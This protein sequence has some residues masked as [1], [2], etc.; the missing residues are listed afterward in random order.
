MFLNIYKYIF[1]T[2]GLAFLAQLVSFAFFSRTLTSDQYHLAVFKIESSVEKPASRVIYR[3]VFGE[4]L[5]QK[6]QQM[7]SDVN[8]AVDL[9]VSKSRGVLLTS[10]KGQFSEESLIG[11]QGTALAASYIV[12]IE[13]QYKNSE[14]FYNDFNFAQKL[15]VISG[16]KVTEFLSEKDKSDM[17]AEV[18]D[19]TSQHLQKQLDIYKQKLGLREVDMSFCEA[20]ARRTE[21]HIPPGD[22]TYSGGLSPEERYPAETE[23]LPSA[24]TFMVPLKRFVVQNRKPDPNLDIHL[25]VYWPSVVYDEPQTREVCL[26]KS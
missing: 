4:R 15:G 18:E 2:I 9:F 5:V 11:S 13:I 12:T 16:E 21:V 10:K 8:K 7:L 19:R 26:A 1:I 3:Y 22:P 20:V 23:K 25:P 24:S 17:L 14:D 6:N